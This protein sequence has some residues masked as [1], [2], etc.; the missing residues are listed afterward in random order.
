[1][2]KKKF[3]MPLPDCLTI[4]NS[5][6]HG[7]GLY[8]SLPIRANTNLGI[9]H[10]KDDRFENGYSRTPLGGFFNHS[11]TPNCKVVYDNDFIYLET[12]KDL[13]PGDELTVTYTFYNPE[14]SITSEEFLT[15]ITK[16]CQE[17]G[18]ELLISNT[19]KIAYP[20][21]EG[22]QVSGY[23]CT[24]KQPILACAIGKPETE[25]YSILVHESCHK[26]QWKEN[27]EVWTDIFANGGNC[28][29]DM[30][31]WLAG[32]DFPLSECVHF[33]RTMQHVEIDCEIR[34]VEKIKNM[35]LPIDIPSYIKAANA[36]LY[37]Y[38]VLLSTR[39][40]C[41]VP[42]Y[43]VPEILELM[44]DRFLTPNSYNFVSPSLME[45]YESKCYV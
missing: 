14:K 36:Y 35:N 22:M 32:K 21:N 17:D 13:F 39:K 38:S 9:T 12:L 28:D 10:I 5:P 31:E 30:D 40:W 34:S 15:L 18:V 11:P 45:L 16:E 25:W 26:D 20:G 6:I 1:M 42:P 3:Y 44:P 23:F 41:D 33:I 24:D 7:L 8:A 37:F 2:E 19:D 43:K 4:M 29:K 27:A